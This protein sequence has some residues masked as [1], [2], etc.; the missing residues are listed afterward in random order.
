MACEQWFNSS[1]L[2]GTY[3]WLRMI[4]CHKQTVWGNLLQTTLLKIWHYLS[5][6][7]WFRLNFGGHLHRSWVSSVD[8]KETS[9]LFFGV[10]DWPCSFSQW[11]LALSDC[12]WCKPDSLSKGIGV[13]IV[14]LV[15]EQSCC[16]WTGRGSLG[17]CGLINVLMTHDIPLAF[18]LFADFTCSFSNFALNIT[19]HPCFHIFT[20]GQWCTQAARWQSSPSFFKYPK[21]AFNHEYRLL[22]VQGFY[23]LALS[24]CYF[25]SVW[26][27][28]SWWACEVY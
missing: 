25:V 3:K 12:W 2:L 4:I 20:E 15:C 19:L 9:L 7:A 28:F 27:G 14:L 6:T 5:V 1:G 18:S 13:L 17:W 11:S 16:G 22:F 24:Q 21:D 10:C 8:I 26:T 23:R